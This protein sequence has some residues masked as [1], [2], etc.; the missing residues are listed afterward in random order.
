MLGTIRRASFDQVLYGWEG[1]I[2]VCSFAYLR[3][4]L[5]G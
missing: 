4:A 5:S 2:A 1:C 3:L